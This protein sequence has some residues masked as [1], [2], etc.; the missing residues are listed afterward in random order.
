MTD[1]LDPESCEHL[2]ID[3]DTHI[4]QDCG[5]DLTDDYADALYDR[6]MEDELGY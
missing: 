2:E 1:Q 5:E 3:E 4:C 6:M